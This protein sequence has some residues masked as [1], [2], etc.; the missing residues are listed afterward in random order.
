MDVAKQE[1]RVRR[2]AFA[3]F[4]VIVAWLPLASAAEPINAAALKELT[5]QCGSE[6]F[7]Q[8][9]AARKQILALGLE[10][11]DA[12]T[13][14]LADLKKSDSNAEARNAVES[15]LHVFRVQDIKRTAKR[16]IGRY[17]DDIEKLKRTVEQELD[18]NAHQANLHAERRA[19][20]TEKLEK[21]EKQL[22]ANPKA[23]DTI[24]EEKVELQTAI[25]AGDAKSKKGFETALKH[26]A[27]AGLEIQRIQRLL[28]DLKRLDNTDNF[29]DEFM[30]LLNDWKGDEWQ[31]TL[32]P[33]KLRLQRQIRAEFVDTPL[34]EVIGFLVSYSG[35]QIRSE[36]MMNE[37]FSI[38]TG[39]GITMEDMLK[40]ICKQ[41]NAQL[42][43]DETSG[44]IKI[45]PNASKS[46]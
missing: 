30:D 23:A 32:I 41:L 14:E 17:T 36:N 1:L 28:T 11:R 25:E 26:K 22:A 8:R 31:L 13:A 40:A 34:E 24:E 33:M 37:N 42:Q 18:E 38:N 39:A 21:I 16:L 10:S 15:A 29:T 3:F 5:R 2:P 19:V 35:M 27:D 46:E 12:L 43:I 4:A 45:K 7:D 6:D 20:W 9:D 44:L